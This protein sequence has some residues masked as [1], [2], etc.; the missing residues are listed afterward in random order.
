M[1]STD[2]ILFAGNAHDDDLLMLFYIDFP[3]SST[4]IDGYLV[5]LLNPPSFNALIKQVDQFLSGIYE[6]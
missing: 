1:G 3:M 4:H 5:F 2:E 6:N